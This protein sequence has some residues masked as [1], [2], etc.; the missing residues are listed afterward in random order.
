MRRGAG[1]APGFTLIEMMA[2][3]LLL[4]L[5]SAVVYPSLRLGSGRAMLSEAEDLGG[6]IE[7]ARQRAIMTGRR[8]RVYIDLDRQ[9]HFVEWIPPRGG[10][11]EPA[12]PEGADALGL[13]LV[14]KLDLSPPPAQTEGSYEPIPGGFGREH[15]L[16]DGVVILEVE[17]P[18]DVQR[19]GEITLELHPDGSAEPALVRVGDPEGKQVYRIEIHALADAVWV[20]RDDR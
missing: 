14:P 18:R 16:P 7:L 13:G 11:F 9:I 2:V 20:D 5:A 6:A 4:A 8:H 15:A 17:F 12:K 1:A 3:T 19:Y 10:N